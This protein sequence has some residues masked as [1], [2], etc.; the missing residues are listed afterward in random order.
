ME[1]AIKE[2]FI[3]LQFSFKEEKERKFLLVSVEGD[4]GMMLIASR[5]HERK[6]HFNFFRLQFVKNLL[7]LKGRHLIN[8]TLA[9]S[10]CQQQPQQ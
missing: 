10:Y 8:V 1:S 4:A 9:W 3:T 5:S 2:F 6:L 7:L